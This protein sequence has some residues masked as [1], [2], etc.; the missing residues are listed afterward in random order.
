MAF[1]PSPPDFARDIRWHR[2]H[3]ISVLTFFALFAVMG[4][5]IVISPVVPAINSTFGI[6]E[7]D[8]G[9]AISGMAMVYAIAQL[10]SG[11]LSDRIGEQAVVFAALVLT[12][13]ASVALAL[14]PSFL[15]FGLFAGLLGASSGLYRTAADSLL[16]RVTTDS[17]T[18][19][20][21]HAAGAAAAG[22]VVPT[23]AV[24]AMQYVGWRGA[25][26]IGGVAAAIMAFAFWWVTQ[27]L[28]ASSRAASD[29]SDSS[30]S[31]SELTLAAFRSLASSKAIVYT[32][33]IGILGNFAFEA[34]LTFFPVFLMQ[35]WGLTA[36]TAGLAFSVVAVCSV[37]GLLVVGRIA[38]TYFAR[39]TMLIGLYGA[40]SLGFVVLLFGPH[41]LSVWVGAVLLGTGLSWSGLLTMR[42]ISIETEVGQAT[43]LGMHKTTVLLVGSLGPVTVGTLSEL[44][45]WTVAYG[46]VAG[47]LTLVTVSLLAI[48]VGS[49]D[50]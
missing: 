17:E 27:P 23:A 3:T 21:S 40:A 18:A 39:D 26:A 33:V 29:H 20:S 45:N 15:L 41:S 12:A 10:A 28:G 9:L 32:T 46:L 2:T 43:A 31:D 35:Y 22:L 36:G 5:R 49:V 6:D 44:F 1:D 13:G 8:I 50:M 30:E 19:I 11:V 37:V 4:A 16:E 38:E 25:I 24:T 14:S 42:F 47:L 48:H 7:S 34:F